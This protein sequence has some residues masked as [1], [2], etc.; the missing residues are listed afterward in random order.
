MSSTGRGSVPGNK[1]RRRANREAQ[2]VEDGD[3]GRERARDGPG[4]QEREWEWTGETTNHGLLRMRRCRGAD[5]GFCCP[6]GWPRRH[7]PVAP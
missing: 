6:A 2:E 4:A 3:K 5:R 1:S 7:S